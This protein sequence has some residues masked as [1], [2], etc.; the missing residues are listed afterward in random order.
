MT[1]ESAERPTLRKLIEA[2][3]IFAKH[4]PGGLDQTFPL[5]TRC[6]LLVCSLCDCDDIPEQSDDGRRLMA[7]GWRVR[8]NTRAWS[9]KL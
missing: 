6:G 9:I 8:C 7:L 2:C 3:E 1:G 4:L 5:E